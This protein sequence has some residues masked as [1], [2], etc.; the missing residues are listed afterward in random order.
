MPKLEIDFQK[1]VIYKIVC[2]D[3][4]VV[5]TYVGMTTDFINR[6]SNHKTKCNNINN[7]RHNLKVYRT[8]RENGGWDNWT[9]L[10]IEAYPCNS[11]LEARL[12][13]R[14]WYEK[15]NA[16]MN[17]NIPLRS[18]EE[19]KAYTKQYQASYKVLHKDKIAEQAKV[20]YENNKEKIINYQSEYNETHKEKI[21][22]RK[23]AYYE[24]NK[25]KV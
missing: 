7:P 11:S 24:K 19:R 25:N 6:K 10:Q 12:K 21:N 8:I 18:D 4:A 23:K 2:I 17:N 1:T 14:E 20:Y 3:L 13:E 15:L 9:M 5:F 16:T 22:K